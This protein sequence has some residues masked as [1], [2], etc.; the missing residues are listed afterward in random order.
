MTF[1]YVSVPIVGGALRTVRIYLSAPERVSSGA[2]N[3]DP[4]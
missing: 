1:T 4:I 2:P 3:S